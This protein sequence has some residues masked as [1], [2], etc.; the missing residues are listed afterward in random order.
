MGV[1]LPYVVLTELTLNKSLYFSKKQCLIKWHLLYLVSFNNCC[2]WMLF[3]I[4]NRYILAIL[5][6]PCMHDILYFVHNIVKLKITRDWNKFLVNIKVIRS[7]VA[8]RAKRYNIP[9]LIYTVSLLNMS[10][11]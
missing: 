4:C 10:S 8:A 5:G 11:N 1:T 9:F 3:G 2:A 6:I 7:L